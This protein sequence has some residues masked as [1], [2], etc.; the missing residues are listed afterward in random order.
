VP[1]TRT[2]SRRDRLAYP[3]IRPRRP[4]E[5][6]GER[7]ADPRRQQLR[8]PPRPL[9]L[10]GGAED[11]TS[12]RPSRVARR[13]SAAA[14]PEAARCLHGPG[15]GAVRKRSRAD[16]LDAGGA[17]SISGLPGRRAAPFAK[18]LRQERGD[19]TSASPRKH[20]PTC[21]A[22]ARVQRRPS[23]FLRPHGDSQASRSAPSATQGCRASCAGPARRPS[24]YAD[25][26]NCEM[27]AAH[28]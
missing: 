7:R 5:T 17:Q 26:C 19:R 13:G 12:A 20:S 1:P 23:G 28:G 21:E 10:P 9:H 4:E 18:S 24:W 11:R 15:P 27:S 8:R 16:G 14:L 2:S 6:F 22:R 3:R 25:G